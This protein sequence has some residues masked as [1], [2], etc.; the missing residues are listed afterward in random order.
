MKECRSSF[1]GKK[2]WSDHLNIHTILRYNGLYIMVIEFHINIHKSEDKSI[3]F[4][5]WS[6]SLLAICHAWLCQKKRCLIIFFWGQ[7]HQPIGA[8]C[9]CAVAKSLAQSVSP[10]KLLP[11]L[12]VHRTRS[13]AQ[14]LLS[15]LYAIGL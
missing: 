6:E 5:S 10:T 12:L 7:F 4:M 15:T 13:S 1:K 2:L 14:L 11:T 3:I 8:K 9:K